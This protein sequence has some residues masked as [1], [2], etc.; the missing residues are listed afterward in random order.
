M[1]KATALTEIREKHAE[2]SALLDKMDEVQM[3]QPNVYGE[4]SVKDVL[5]HI[6]AWERMMMR[7]LADSQRGQIPDRFA[8]GFI[9]KQD[10]PEEV[11]DEVINRLNDKVYRENKDRPLAEVMA[12]FQTAHSEV[13]DDIGG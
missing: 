6:I 2:L 1:D 5:A 13:L 7:W 9:V 12:D 8:P 10:D 4:L 3:T 11:M